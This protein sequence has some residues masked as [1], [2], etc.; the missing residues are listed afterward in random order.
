MLRIA[1]P[2][3]EC[4]SKREKS[5]AVIKLIKMAAYFNEDPLSAAISFS[6]THSEA[7]RYWVV[8]MDPEMSVNILTEA[9]PLY[10]LHSIVGHYNDTEHI[11]HFAG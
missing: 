6:A 8:I 7:Q 1:A 10:W 9:L 2:K 4:A 5:G 3:C 11:D